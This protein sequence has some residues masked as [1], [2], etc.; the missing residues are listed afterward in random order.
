MLRL[1]FNSALY[2]LVF[3]Q[4]GAPL[5]FE[6]QSLSS[7][8]QNGRFRCWEL[9]SLW[10]TLAVDFWASVPGSERA[11]FATENF[12]SL[13]LARCGFLSFISWQENGR[14]SLLRALSLKSCWQVC[15]WASTMRTC[16][17]MVEREQTR[18]GLLSLSS[19]IGNGPCFRCSEPSSKSHCKGTTFSARVQIIP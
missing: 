19:C 5:C 7:S 11:V 18:S 16:S 15:D 10:F 6:S 12:V 2:A 4:R 14:F 17:L 9:L 1:H 8:Q 3:S 13:I